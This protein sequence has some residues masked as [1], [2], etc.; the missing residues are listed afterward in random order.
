[1]ARK[2]SVNDKGPTLGRDAMQL[3]GRITALQEGEPKPAELARYRV[4]MTASGKIKRGYDWD[5]E[6]PA[7][8]LKRDVQKFN[9]TGAYVNA[10]G[11]HVPSFMQS[12]QDKVGYFRRVKWN[13]E[14]D[15]IDGDLVLARTPQSEAFK[16]QLDLDLASNN[17]MVQFSAVY[18][19]DFSEEETKR[20]GEPYYIVK[21]EKIREVFS[22]DAVDK[23]AF[24]MRPLA[25][26]S[27][28]KQ[29]NLQEEE[30]MAQEKETALNA[31]QE[32]DTATDKGHSEDIATLRANYEALQ[33]RDAERDA[34]D[35][36]REAALADLQKRDEMR[37]AQVAEL[38]KAAARSN[39]EAHF[40][41]KVATLPADDAGVAKLREAIKFDEVDTAGIDA[42]VDPFIAS[43]TAA[44]RV[45]VEDEKIKVTQDVSDKRAG[46]LT[47]SVLG[48]TY[49]D[50]KD[51]KFEVKG[52]EQI[53]GEE[54]GDKAA[55][56]SPAVVWDA[57]NAAYLR[58]GLTDAEVDQDAMG[59]PVARLGDASVGTGDSWAARLLQ[60][61]VTVARMLHDGSEMTGW[62]NT[63]IPAMHR[64]TVPDFNDRYYR[65]TGT[66]E[67][68]KTV[69]EDAQVPD[70][71]VSDAFR[72]PVKPIKKQGKFYL[73]YEAVMNSPTAAMRSLA[74]AM[75]VSISST[76]YR[77]VLD[78]MFGLGGADKPPRSLGYEQATG[79]TGVNFLV[80]AN[81]N[82]LSGAASGGRPA[83]GSFSYDQAEIVIN[84][85]YA[86]TAYG[87]DTFALAG[88]IRAATLV[89]PPAEWG[90]ADAITRAT[91]KPGSQDND[92]NRL[93]GMTVLPISS[94][95]FNAAN[96]AKVFAVVARP[97]DA[98]LFVMSTLAG[99][100]PAFQ[101]NVLRDDN[102]NHNRITYKASH[103][104]RFTLVDRR[105]IV[106]SEAA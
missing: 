35:A 3:S 80:A 66:Y 86:Q 81:G 9:K 36:E 33:K 48:D 71:N 50:E 82:L 106:V 8:V 78:Q 75:G 37:D 11:N 42:L 98:Q 83:G 22:V 92:V 94:T 103:I 79:D 44:G 91:L 2:E 87:E 28:W 77:E 46:L 15:T 96:L 31:E 99:Q 60:T 32:V 84:H 57:L 55:Q 59:R 53:I 43:L 20:N 5:L 104:R 85:M 12:V 97:A 63:L 13:P 16:G 74:T 90:G 41:A 89:V 101:P 73:T 24:P 26:L 29:G 51:N 58:H 69:A 70:V 95:A 30:T 1:M 76:D 47:A 67:Q 14:S 56:Y 102:A 27:E 64:V 52:I 100:P 68:L 39:N 61:I 10:Q 105:A 18:S 25:A 21:V 88:M 4:Q 34:K 19:Y 65:Y 93:Q 38:A 54:Y 6:I 72:V 7:A 62:L 45:E 49:T 17:A 23:G 40:D